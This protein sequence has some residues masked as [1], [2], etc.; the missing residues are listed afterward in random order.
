[1]KSG[2][3]SCTIKGIKKAEIVNSPTLKSFQTAFL[4]TRFSFIN[5]SLRPPK[6]EEEEEE[7]RRK[8]LTLNCV[9]VQVCDG[10]IYKLCLIEC[11]NVVYCC[12][13]NAFS[14]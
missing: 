5:Q 9:T 12:Y 3:L 7:R 2:C 1:M 11:C 13:C 8:T 4:F 10:Y 14:E 6:D